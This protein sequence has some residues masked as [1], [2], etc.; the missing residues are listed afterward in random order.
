[1]YYDY[2][3]HASVSLISIFP[4]VFGKQKFDTVFV[5]FKWN[6]KGKKV[7]LMIAKNDINS[8]KFAKLEEPLLNLRKFSNLNF[9]NHLRIRKTHF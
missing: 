6:L 3:K 2:M 4:K 9:I 5:S 8:L 7:A 1:M